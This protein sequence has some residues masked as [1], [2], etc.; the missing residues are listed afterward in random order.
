MRKGKQARE[1]RYVTYARLALEA[2]RATF[3]AYRHRNSP[4]T[5][6][7]PQ[8]IACVLLGFYL[9]LSYRDLEDW[10][11]A[12][13]SVCQVLGLSEVPDHS[14]LNRTMQ[15]VQLHALEA[16]HEQVLARV[17][18]ETVA[19]A[20]DGTGFR[21]TRASQHYVSRCGRRMT[22]YPQ[23]FY[24]VSVEQRYILAWRYA[25]GPSG[26][27]APYWAC[28]RRRTRRFLK[29][30]NPHAH[31]LLLGDKGF[32]GPTARPYDLIPPRQGQHPVRRPDRR[33]RLE[34]VRQ[35]R[36]EGIYG[37]RWQSETVMS[38]MKRK[39]GDTLRSLSHRLQRR[40]IA[41]KALAYNLHVFSPPFPLGLCNRAAEAGWNACRIG[42]VRV[43]RNIIERAIR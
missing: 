22:D 6:T 41:W 28:L 9:D 43:F 18:V 17:G 14:T 1:S 33:Q 7:Q 40:E 32:D 10:L 29:P 31:W 25:R 27:D 30:I 23:G 19:V 13:N 26:S 5:Y 20:I 34:F 38:V 37:Q 12:S 3:P 35:A 2:T 11:L 8:L 39:S 4:K 16:L 15:R 21:A 24:A 36:L 42:D